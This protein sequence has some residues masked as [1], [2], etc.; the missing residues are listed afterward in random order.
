MKKFFFLFFTAI[1][2]FSC[3]NSKKFTVEGTIENADGKKLYLEYNGLMK[4]VLLDSVKIKKDGKYHFSSA[5]P[6]YPDFYRLILDG[7]YIIFAIDSIEKITINSRYDGFA[8]NYVVENSPQNI[9]IQRLRQSLNAVQILADSL[10]NAPPGMLPQMR[11][12]LENQITSHKDSAKALIF[13]NARSLSAYFALFQQIN[14]ITLFSPYDSQDMVY[15]N[16]VATAF[17]VFMPD[18]ERS[19]SLYANAIDAINRDREQ[20]W[21]EQWQQ[22]QK[23]NGIGF[24]D[25]ALPDVKG[26]ERKLSE[27]AKGK[28]VLLDFSS[29]DMQDR[30]NYIFLLRDLY[31]KF[32]PRGFT[33]YQVS[34]DENRLLWER[35]SE[36]LPWICVRS[37]DG[38]NNYYTGVYNIQN[39]PTLF[40]LNKKGDIVSRITD[41][42]TIAKLVSEN[43]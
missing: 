29:S 8:M 10:Q 1:F 3:D 30:T 12:R 7:K 40:L 6:Q 9:E 31:N 34:L 16:A 24:V 4:S 21:Q 23:E 38:A 37:K 17:N 11:Q 32:S 33:I 27:I 2:F 13:K 20:K 26:N 15:Y 22:L 5:R 19:K 43:L 41:L 28:T 18:Y 35:S 42:K 36:N 14:G 25:I 39:N